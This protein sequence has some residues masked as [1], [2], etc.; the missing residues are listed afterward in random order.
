MLYDNFIETA[1]SKKI[2]KIKAI[3][4]P[5]NIYPRRTHKKPLIKF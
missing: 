5:V 2:H 3:T 4:K 1:R